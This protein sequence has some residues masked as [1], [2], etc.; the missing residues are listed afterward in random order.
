MRSTISISALALLALTA[1]SVLGAD[2]GG[3]EGCQPFAIRSRTRQTTPVV[4]LR[5]E[6]KPPLR[7]A[8]GGQTLPCHTAP[9]GAISFVLPGALLPDQPQTAQLFEA[10]DT[11]DASPTLAEPPAPRDF[12]TDV[13]GRPWT[14]ASDDGGVL[15][16]GDQPDHIGP[17]TFADGWMN[18]TVMKHDPYLVWGH[19]FEEPPA[20][21]LFV[22]DSAVYHR[23][24]ITLR[25]EQPNQT[26]GIFVTDSRGSYYRHNFTVKPAGESTVSLDLSQIYRQQW[27]GR[28]FRALR[29]DL[30][31]RPG[32]TVGLKSIRL[33]ARSIAGEPRP[34]LTGDQRRTLAHAARLVT[35]R[36]EAS[37]QAGQ[38][39]DVAARLL[40]ATG[41]PL[42]NRPCAWQAILEQPDSG[43][44]LQQHGNAVTDR[45]GRFVATLTL[46]ALAQPWQLALGLSTET[47]DLSGARAD[48]PLDVRPAA[49]D[50]L[51]FQFATRL[52]PPGARVRL[53]IQG[54]DAFGNRVPVSLPKPQWQT[55]GGAAVDASD[56]PLSGNPA[57]ATL[58]L[59]DR[60]QATCTL[61]LAFGDGRVCSTTLVTV[62]TQPRRDR[63]AIGPNGYLLAPDGR[64]FLPTG[65][66]YANWPHGLPNPQTT[67]IGRTID[68]FPCGAIPYR[69]GFPWS[70]ETEAKVD[71]YLELCSRYG[72][73]AQRLMLRN[74]DLVGKVDETQLMAV[75]HFIDKAHARGIRVNVALLEDYQKPPYGNLD[76]LEK[77]VL[78]HYTR[79]ELAALPPHR[80]RFLVER[81]LLTSAYD[82]YRDEDSIRCQEDFLRQLIPLLATREGIFCYEYENEMTQQALPY[83]TRLAKLIRSLD[84]HTLLLVNPH[85]IAWPMPLAWRE[86]PIDLFCDHPYVMGQ[87]DADRGAAI[88]LRAKW[89]LAS[90]KTALTGEGGL[91]T[92]W[93]W[94]GPSGVPLDICLPEARRA[95]RDHTWMSLS[96]GLAGTMHWTVDLAC[97]PEELGRP[98]EALRQL[99]ADLRTFRRRQADV[100][101]VM[102]D[103]KELNAKALSLTFQLLRRGVSF[104]TV[105]ADEATPYRA[106]VH[107]DETSAAVLDALPAFARPL[108]GYQTSALRSSDG[109][110]LIYLRN[111]AGVHLPTEPYNGPRD[112]TRTVVPAQPGLTLAADVAFTSAHAYDLDDARLVPLH[113]DGQR[114]TLPAPSTH[115]FIIFLK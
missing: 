2:K 50:R 25:Q 5:S 104:D 109:Q 112:A 64:L 59:P 83:I 36:P 105:P 61:K 16:Y 95:A 22:L 39:A 98:H 86:S 87:P 107:A 54:R 4:T 101:L 113:R 77:V 80:R 45:D 106:T 10:A 79:E 62:P 9:D 88:L 84:P 3:L 76:V 75:L 41:Q 20:N 97:E 70:P 55:T 23:L 72:L 30:P 17:R 46:P 69:E 26:W 18:M 27:N 33:L 63:I 14:F 65:G 48:L 37:G 34:A 114:L 90:R 93:R 15:K 102:P 60:P 108:P 68:L 82:R 52:L 74:L 13:L 100:A 38:T 111:A 96:A 53:A 21:D 51:E 78:P 99:G 19:M 103:S 115:D 81:R 73:T 35:E 49:L 66:L 71:E 44:R 57:H 8:V 67:T 94:H 31:K 7:L 32:L 11:A 47:G 58:T 89:C 85:P 29:L 6:L 28:L 12:A 40:D 43:Q 1:G 24:V 56:A 91:F 92:S 42:T 110:T